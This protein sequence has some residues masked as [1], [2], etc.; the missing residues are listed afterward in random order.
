MVKVDKRSRRDKLKDGQIN[1]IQVKI[2][3]L[4]KESIEYI[5]KIQFIADMVKILNAQ[6]DD[7]KKMCVA[8]DADY[9]RNKPHGQ[10]AT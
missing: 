2:D 4:T 1:N 5:G 6:I 8:Q 9:K 3:A 7:I 10:K